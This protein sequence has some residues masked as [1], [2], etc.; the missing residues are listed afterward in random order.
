MRGRRKRGVAVKA[1][2]T[3][4]LMPPTAIAEF[5]PNLSHVAMTRSTSSIARLRGLR[6]LLNSH[7]N[8]NRFKI[9]AKGHGNGSFSPIPVARQIFKIN[10]TCYEKAAAL[11]VAFLLFPVRRT[12]FSLS[13]LNSEQN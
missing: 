3:T 4:I 11:A 7:A 5:R 12:S 8:K 1:A 9:S 10:I 2:A 13:E 6:H